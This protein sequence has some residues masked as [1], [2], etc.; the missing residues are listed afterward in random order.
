MMRMFG[1]FDYAEA[2]P[3]ITPTRARAA[4]MVRPRRDVSKV[5]SFE[6]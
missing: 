6:K 5:F 4:I 2:V 1:F 3:L